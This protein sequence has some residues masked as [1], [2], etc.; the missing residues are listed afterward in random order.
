M[1]PPPI[2]EIYDRIGAKRNVRQHGAQ[3]LLLSHEVF[4]GFTLIYSVLKHMDREIV[5]Y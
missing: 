3:N 2:S 5:I 1:K 4:A